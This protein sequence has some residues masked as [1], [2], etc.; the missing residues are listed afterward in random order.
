MKKKGKGWSVPDTTT[1]WE[2]VE[3]YYV[4]YYD[5]HGAGP[6]CIL[7]KTK[8]AAASDALQFQEQDLEAFLEYLK[9]HA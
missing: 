5:Y 6:R 3:G 2:E 9:S 7:V 1:G 8:W 4:Q